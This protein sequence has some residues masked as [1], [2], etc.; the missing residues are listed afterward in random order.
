M[1]EY[2]TVDDLPWGPA[3]PERVATSKPRKC[4]HRKAPRI[5]KNISPEGVEPVHAE[6]CGRCGHVFD[7]AK[8]KQGKSSN[9]IA[10][11]IERWVGKILRLSRV[12]QYGGQEDVGKADE[13]ALA[14]VKSGPQWF[15]P[16]MYR[17]IEALKPRAG[18]RRALVVVSKPGS[19]GV[20]QAMWI[21]ILDEVPLPGAAGGW[22]ADAEGDVWCG[23]C[24]TAFPN[25][26]ESC[27]WS[28]QRA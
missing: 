6:T 15:S 14:Q 10:K 2:E 24:G 17:E 13:W 27:V 5:W 1:K 23:V 11:D 8:Q 4:T 18:Q 9:N 19:S 21:E 3:S 20:R 28:H 22:E 26:S 25:H 12:G 7:P 16:K